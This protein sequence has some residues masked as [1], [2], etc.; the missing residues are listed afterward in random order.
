MC[1][2]CPLHPV[3]FA[4]AAARVGFNVAVVRFARG[5]FRTQQLPTA[6]LIFPNIFIRVQ[7]AGVE[8]RSAACEGDAN[9]GCNRTSHISCGAGSAW[10][11]R[12]ARD[13]TK[14]LARPLRARKGRVKAGP[15]RLLHVLVLPQPSVFRSSTF[16]TRNACFSAPVR[17]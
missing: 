6:C 10:P 12:I 5:A 13:M 17:R 1:L 8:P 2:F 11:L 4:F 9:G 7:S 15:D 3:G 14:D 16:P